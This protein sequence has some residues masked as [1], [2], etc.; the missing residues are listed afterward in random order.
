LRHKSNAEQEAAQGPVGSRTPWTVRVRT[1]LE[2]TPPAQ[3]LHGAIAALLGVRVGP[4]WVVEA[5]ALVSGTSGV[6]GRVAWTPTS[7]WIRPLLAV[8]VPVLFSG[9]PSVGVGGSAGLQARLTEWLSVGVE[10]V[11]DL[12]ADL[13]QALG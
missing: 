6:L 10:E 8:E 13:E 9:P 5:G 3:K 1:Q 12:I 4:S 7:Y 11:E 2:L